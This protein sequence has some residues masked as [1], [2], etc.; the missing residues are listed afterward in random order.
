MEQVKD[1]AVLILAA[2]K[3]SRMKSNKPKVMHELAGAPLVHYVMASALALDPVSVHTIIAPGMEETVGQAVAPNPVCLQTEQKGTGHAVAQAEDVLKDFDGTV[4]V[5]LGDVP[6]IRTDTLS[7]LAR[8]LEDNKNVIELLTFQPEDPTGYGRVLTNA[9]QEVEAIV[10]QKDCTPEQA[11]E[12]RVWS[13]CM[14]VDGQQLFKLLSEVSDDNAQQEYYLTSIVE[15]A[16]EKGLSVGFLDTDTLQVQGI[17]SKIDLANLEQQVQQMLRHQHLDAGVV[18]QDPETVYFSIDTKIA[19]DVVV[20]PHIFFGRDVVVET[21]SHIKAF[22]HIEGAHIGQDSI[23][24]PFARLRPETVL[25]GKNDIGNFVEIKK[26]TVGQGSKVKHLS[27]IGDAIIGEKANLGAGTITCNYNGY[28]KFKTTI[29]DH[30]FTGVNS[31]LVAPCEI[32]A[33]AITAAGSVITETVP[34]G[35]LA[36]ARS[37]QIIKEGWAHSFHQEKQQ[38]KKQGKKA[39]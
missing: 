7:A 32:G 21:G 11:L 20:E 38:L 22:S 27:Y 15:I 35:A 19:P 36:V 39:S 29:G 31:V 4:L 1:I 13:G 9:S 26:T 3:G 14:A 34:E 37:K 30:A 33:S 5:L 6:L 18:L 24:G 10:E 16:R 12:R 25:Q 28:N 2:G 17:N 23:V 8:S